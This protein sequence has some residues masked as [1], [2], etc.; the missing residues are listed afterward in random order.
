[1]LTQ[2]C[3]P[4][5]PPPHPTP[6]SNHPTPTP[7]HPREPAQ[8]RQR[9]AVQPALQI[10]QD[11]RAQPAHHGNGAQRRAGGKQIVAVRHVQVCAV[12]LG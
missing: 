6:P 8:L 5:A 9:L 7:P 12:G 11:Q 1:M 10:I 3:N 4:H 2:R